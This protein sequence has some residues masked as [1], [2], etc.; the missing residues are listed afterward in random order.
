MR[1]PA[2]ILSLLPVALVAAGCTDLGGYATLPG[3]TYRGTVLGVEESTVLLRGFEVG[4]EMRLS[5]D[6][7]LATSLDEP[8]GIVTTS[9]GA[10]T[11]VPLEPIVPLAHDALSEYEIPAGG[12]IRNYIF[13]VR[14]SDGPLAGREPF[15]F[16]SLM[17]D[18]TIE[19]RVIAG[20]GD[21]DPPTSYFG[22]WRLRRE[23][24]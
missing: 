5:F 20:G 23:A 10:L 6:P 11:D 21:D 9:D 2:L 8:P 24:P 16:L 17:N 19:V 3:E 1:R 22:L 4:A 14:P 13:V 18:G 12:R 15:V 7:R